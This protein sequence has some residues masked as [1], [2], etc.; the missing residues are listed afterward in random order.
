MTNKK[1]FISMMLVAVLILSALCVFGFAAQT[2]VAQAETSMVDVY[3][4]NDFHGAVEK[5]PR[6]AGYLAKRKAEGAIILNSGDM[7]QGSM[8]S[9][10]NF[11]KLYSLSRCQHLQ[12]EPQ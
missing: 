12:L 5:M 1:I 4:I 11:G 10:S 8:E 3:A 2:T 7:F 9:N 6:I